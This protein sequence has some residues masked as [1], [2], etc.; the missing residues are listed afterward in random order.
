MSKFVA[1]NNSIPNC[2]RKGNKEKKQAY[3]K[4]DGAI[5]NKQTEKQIGLFSHYGAPVAGERA[6]KIYGKIVSYLPLAEPAAP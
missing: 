1:M 2:H 5:V 6:C 3:V 4:I